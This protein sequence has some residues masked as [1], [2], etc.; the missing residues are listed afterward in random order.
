MKICTKSILIV[1]SVLGV[2]MAAPCA[3]ISID[4]LGTVSGYGQ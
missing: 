4:F 1:A 3:C 2:E